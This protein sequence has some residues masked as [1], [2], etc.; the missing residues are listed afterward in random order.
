MSTVWPLPKITFKALNEM[1]E[2]RPVALLTS[3]SAWER[4][5]ASLKLPLVVQAEPAVQ[6]RELIDYLS[7]NLPSQAEVVYVVGTGVPLTVGKIV[8][9]ANKLPLVLI[10]TAIDS[11]ELFEAHVAL[12][13]DGLVTRLQT[14]A[15]TEV[16][17]DWA[18]IEAAPPHIRA[19]A[20]VDVLAIVTALLD[21]RYAAKENKSAP[22]QKFSGWSAGIAA[23][24]ATQSI[25]IAKG[26]GEG[27]VE[28]LRTLV[29]IVMMSVQLAHQ[30]G[31]DRHQEGT[32][33]YLAYALQNQGAKFSHAEAV[34]P[35]M[36][37][38]SALHGQ[39]P[40]ALRTALQ[41]AGIRLDQLRA[42]D[43]RLAVNDLPNFCAANDFPY[44]IAHSLDPLSEEVTEALEK[45]G[46]QTSA[47]D[48]NNWEIPDAV[49]QAGDT[50]Q[51]PTAE[52]T[53]IQPM[54]A[55][56]P[57]EATTMTPPTQSSNTPDDDQFLA[58]ILDDN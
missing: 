29:D 42:G 33:H 52:D 4:V 36:L 21:W 43:V 26:V 17:I 2:N 57:N 50:I 13:N 38:T 30:L 37:F 40:A 12:F 23:S 24:L 6:D 25:K 31:H 10:P 48:T 1:E 28:S 44:A 18:V 20:I 58:T 19:A 8:A 46:L 47:G 32:E 34:G 27:N 11:D 55:T 51:R 35:G 5:G 3:D 45:A 53:P 9:H 7:N 15:P 16:I 22:D 14:G 54:Q 49:V 39:D 56:T 41:D